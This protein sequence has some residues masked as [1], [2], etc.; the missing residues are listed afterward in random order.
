MGQAGG[1]IVREVQAHET[2]TLK[3]IMEIER[4]AF[5][6]GGLVNEWLLIPVLR[7]GKLFVAELAQA[8]ATSEDKVIGCA[9]FL[10]T[11]AGEGEAYMYGLSLLP[12]YRGRGLGTEFLAKL[13]LKLKTE[14]ITRLILSVSPENQGA[15]HLY[16]DKAGFEDK[17]Y[18]RDEYGPGEDRLL[19]ELEL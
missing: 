7:Y 1:V 8:N 9:Q 13:I 4:Q 3:S 12:S 5:G 6:N 11:W 2:N 14:G 10:K 16:R 17:A 15:L 19:M 18:V